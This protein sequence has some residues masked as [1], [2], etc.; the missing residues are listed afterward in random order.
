MRIKLLAVALATLVVV[1][2]A[3]CDRRD[4]SPS[5]ES[6]GVVPSPTAVGSNVVRV[7]ADDRGFTPGSITVNRGQPTTLQFVRTSDATCAREVVVPA[8][9]VK[10]SLPLNTP[11]EVA[12]AATDAKTYEF[13]C[14][15]GMFKGAVVVR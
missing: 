15:M 5:P 12:I 10:R 7:T 6:A 1:A 8:L 2:V 9:N 11:V 14:G 13:A 3:G 4:S